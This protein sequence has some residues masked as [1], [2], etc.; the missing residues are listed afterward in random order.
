AEAA[1]AVVAPIKSG[2]SMCMLCLTN[3]VASNDLGCGANMKG[4]PTR[5]RA[6]CGMGANIQQL[7]LAKEALLMELYFK[8]VNRDITNGFE[9]EYFRHQPTLRNASLCIKVAEHKLPA[10]FKANVVVAKDRSGK[11]KKIERSEKIRDLC[12][13][14]NSW[15]T[16]FIPSTE[17][18]D[19]SYFMTQY[20][21][22]PKDV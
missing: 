8:I 17:E 3:L 7:T 4:N 10:D 21:W 16:T 19:T 20:I 11:Y 6:N 13:E 2:K 22:N 9:A 18:L 5:C 1:P 14:G 15:H 12:Q